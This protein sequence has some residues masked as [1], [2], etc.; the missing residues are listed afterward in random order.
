MIAGE[1]VNPRPEPQG[2]TTRT[3][4]AAAMKAQFRQLAKFILRDM[5]A[6]APRRRRTEDT[7]RAAFKLAAGKIMRR[8][9][10]LP[11]AA[12]AAAAFLSDTLDWLNPWHNEADSADELQ[13]DF[14]TTET[15]ALFPHL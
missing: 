4:L 9:V 6:P 13:E 7:G 12:Y 2:A 1:G 8:A 10:R 15:N 5:P 3:T 11:A 14:H